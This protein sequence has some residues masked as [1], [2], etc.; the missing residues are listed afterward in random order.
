MAKRYNKYEME[1][2]KRTAR[3]NKLDKFVE[4]ITKDKK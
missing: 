1:H 2:A 4:L 3:N